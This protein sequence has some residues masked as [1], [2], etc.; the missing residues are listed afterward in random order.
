MPSLQSYPLRFLI[1]RLNAFGDTHTPIQQLRQRNDRAMNGLKPPS[2]VVTQAVQV[3]SVPAE[4]IIPAG[5][6]ADQA[7][8]YFHGGAFVMGSIATHRLMVSHLAL[9]GQSRVLSIDYRLAP[10]YPFPAALDD[11]VESYRWLL[12]Q[13]IAP[14]KIVIAGDSAGG[15]LALVLLLKLRDDGHPLPAAAV[16]ISPVTDL[17]G[18][19]QSRRTKAKADPV[20]GKGFGNT[21]I[22]TSYSGKYDLKHPYLSPLFADLHGLPPTLLHVGEDEI[23]FDD[24]VEF[25]ENACKAGVDAH[26]VIWPRMWHVFQMFAPFLP[27]ANQSLAQIGAFVQQKLS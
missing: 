4:W 17:E 22:P 3:G 1:G 18:T 12:Q 14:G 8:L 5:A 2:Q 24:S 20:L 23:L 25:V 26:L 11:C 27:E 6:P 15:N 21:G 19:R 9:A 10:E 7:V 13:G 16:C